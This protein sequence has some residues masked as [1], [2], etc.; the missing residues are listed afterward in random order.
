[1]GDNIQTKITGHSHKRFKSKLDSSQNIIST[2]LC[3]KYTHVCTHTLFNDFPSTVN[4]GRQ[5]RH[6]TNAPIL[7]PFKIFS[8]NYWNLNKH[9]KVD[10]LIAFLIYLPEPE[11]AKVTKTQY[12]PLRKKLMLCAF[13]ACFI[14]AIL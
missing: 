2:S 10:L 11:S 14:A 7:F 5:E 6:T 8:L 9:L 12:P 13:R 3:S 4:P 1:M